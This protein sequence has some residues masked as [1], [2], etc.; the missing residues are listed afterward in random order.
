MFEIARYTADKA[1]AWNQF[2]ATARNAT[3]LLD[4]RYMDYHSD[5]FSDHSLMVYREGTLF[6]LLPAN[7]EGDTWCSHRGLTY[8]GL[9]TD[10]HATA[11]RVVQLFRELNDYLRQAGFRR[12]VYKPVPH[13][14]HRI[15]A[16]EDLYALSAVC[17]ARLAS[18]CISSTIDLSQRLPW[19]HSRRCGINKAPSN[20]VLLGESDDWAGFWDV[21]MFNLQHKYSARPVHSL[22]EIQLLHERFPQ[23][24][25]LFTAAKDGQVLGGT[26]VYVTPMAVHT[27]YISANTE[28][29]RLRVLDALFD[30]LLHHCTWDAR[31]F[32]FGTSNEDQGRTLVEP[33]IYQKEGFGGRGICYD[34]YEWEL[35]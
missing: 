19:H 21:L 34:T 18:R 31:Y 7:E 14:F 35:Q 26:V 28:G 11:A 29:K 32:D 22:S 25:R 24:I 5:R 16:E 27:Q 23:H 8:G 15:P 10:S 13:I 4:R 3:F 33:L 1:G 6:A 12:A 2:V 9:L 30:H 20:G 17:G